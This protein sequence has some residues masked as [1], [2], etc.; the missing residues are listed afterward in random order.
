MDRRNEIVSRGKLII[1]DKD[2][3]VLIKEISYRCTDNTDS[4]NR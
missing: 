3:L 2:I 4:V 1:V